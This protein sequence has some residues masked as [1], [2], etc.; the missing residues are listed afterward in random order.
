MSPIYRGWFRGEKTAGLEWGIRD[1]IHLED[2]HKQQPIYMGEV[3]KGKQGQNEELLDY[4]NSKILLLDLEG[5]CK[6]SRQ[7]KAV[8]Y[9]E[10]RKWEGGGFVV[11]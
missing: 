4:A 5:N 10:D 3:D 6:T 8:P 9:M 11:W 2:D 1:E 7:S